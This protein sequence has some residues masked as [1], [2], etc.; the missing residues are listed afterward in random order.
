M[1]DKTLNYVIIVDVERFLSYIGLLKQFKQVGT[2]GK[3]L[4]VGNCTEYTHK[5]PSMK[6]FTKSL[7]VLIKKN[8]QDSYQTNDFSTVL[9]KSGCF[10]DEVSVTILRV[11]KFSMT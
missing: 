7:S 11:Y 9:V 3:V 10:Q 1:S 6:P 8:I 4:L 2:Q 5:T